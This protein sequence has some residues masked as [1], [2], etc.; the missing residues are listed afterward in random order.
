MFGDDD[1]VVIAPAERFAAALEAAEH[2]GRAERAM[3]AAMRRGVA[4]HDLTNWAEHVARAG[5]RRGAAGSSSMSTTE[6][7]LDAAFSQRALDQ[8]AAELATILAGARPACCR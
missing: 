8:G 2:I 5:P 4:L 1:G 6:P 3:L 7:A